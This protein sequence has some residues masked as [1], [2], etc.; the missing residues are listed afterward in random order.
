MSTAYPVAGKIETKSTAVAAGTGSKSY[1]APVS[2][3]TGGARRE[4]LSASILIGAILFIFFLQ[5]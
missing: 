5:L 2:K 1:T 3:F 4:G